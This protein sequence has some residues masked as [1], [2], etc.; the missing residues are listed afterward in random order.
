MPTHV[1]LALE[2]GV[3]PRVAVFHQRPDELVD[4]VRM[5]A[6]V[7]R[8]LDEREV[9]RV[10]DRP[11]ELADFLGQKMGVVG[12]RDP[13][14]DLR[15]RLLRRVH[16]VLL[17]LDQRPLEALLRP[18]DVEALAVLPGRVEQE[19]PD[20]RRD[21]ASPRI[22]MWHDSTAK[23][24]PDFSA[25]SSGRSC[26]SRSSLRTPPGREPARAPG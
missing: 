21:V 20:V 7:A 15:L 25:N 10:L 8:P 13:L 19:P 5:R 22:L 3:G 12:H 11:R 6:A 16:D 17:A 18:V 9:L 24:L 23:R 14:R 26:P 2:R 4:Q 1:Q